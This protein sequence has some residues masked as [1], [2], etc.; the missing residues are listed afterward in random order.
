[1]KA[2]TDIIVKRFSHF[3]SQ[4]GLEDTILQQKYR[5]KLMEEISGMDSF[6]CLLGNMTPNITSEFR[7]D[8]QNDRSLLKKKIPIPS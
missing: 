7:I 1:M 4:V 2:E 3:S 6:R 8:L 5:E